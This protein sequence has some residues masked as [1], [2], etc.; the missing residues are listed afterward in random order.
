MRPSST[1]SSAGASGSLSGMIEPLPPLWSSMIAY[2]HLTR[3]DLS[4]LAQHAS[5]FETHGQAIVDAFYQEMRCHPELTELV[6]QH[7]SYERLKQ[8]ALRYLL[9][10]SHPIIDDDYVTER[11]RIG[12]AHVRVGLSQEW[13]I[14]SVGTYVRLI[15]ERLAFLE[16]TRLFDAAVKRLFFDAAIMVN[17]YV[18]ELKEAYADAQHQIRM[19]HWSAQIQEYIW[20][21]DAVSEA[22]ANAAVK[23]A[24]T[25]AAIAAEMKA[26]SCQIQDIKTFSSFIL[27][28]AEQTNMLGLNAS[29]EAARVGQS[30][31]GFTIVATEIRKLAD[32]SRDSVRQ[33]GQTIT[34]IL[35]S[36]ARVQTRIEE[37]SGIT[38]GQAA[39]SEELRAII[40]QLNDFAQQSE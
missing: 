9:S 34:R 29:I 31:K 37:A 23:T 27:E 1:I 16:D 32:R 10:L 30:G 39:T 19:K 5:F 20:N 14:V 17:Q 13:V 22:H 8:T 28:I 2:L 40:S 33:I 26:L 3:D 12:T 21:I 38:E 18:A 35:E 11:A 7:T 6:E 4:I 25:Q 15:R 36:S 24:E